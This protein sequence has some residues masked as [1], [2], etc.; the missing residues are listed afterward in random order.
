MKLTQIIWHWVQSKDGIGSG[1]RIKEQFQ[2]IIWGENSRCY[3][4]KMTCIS[5]FLY[6]S[7]MSPVQPLCSLHYLNAQIGGAKEE[8]QQLSSDGQKLLGIIL[9]KNC[10]IIYMF[11]CCSLETSHPRLLPQSPKV[12]SVHLCLF[13]C[14]AYRVIVTIFLN[15]IYMC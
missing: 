3:N 13:F 15:S 12:C 2:C 6:F 14:F 5:Q 7:E 8:D 1:R 9:K 11:R 4:L 10:L